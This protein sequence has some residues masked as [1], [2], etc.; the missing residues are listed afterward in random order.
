[1]LPIC[2][3]AFAGLLLVMIAAV[4]VVAQE[5]DT[6]KAKDGDAKVKVND[7]AKE[8]EAAKSKESD[9]TKAKLDKAK[10]AYESE[11]KKQREALIESFQKKEESAARAGDK[12]LRDQVRLQREKFSTKGDLPDVIPANEYRWRMKQAI[13]AMEAAYKQALKDY[14]IA[15]KDY[16]ADLVDKELA[17]FKKKLPTFS[18][19][20]VWVGM[21]GSGRTP[22]KLEIESMD[23]VNFTGRYFILFPDGTVKAQDRVDGKIEKGTI[24]FKHVNTKQ[25]GV[26]VPCVAVGAITANRI[27]G[28]W[29]T[30]D[31]GGKGT[32]WLALETKKK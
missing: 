21:T 16:D 23:G 28:T 10:A 17:E 32:F 30:I 1:M 14:L 15:K 20:E 25:P 24:S 12:S 8:G 6:S 4:G 31:G 18:T 26:L 29:E 9:A 27:E 7:K 13:A 19:P 3:F 22:A 5:A 11:A 2:R